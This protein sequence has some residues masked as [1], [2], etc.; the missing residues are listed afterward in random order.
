MQRF[1]LATA[2]IVAALIT[3]P[4][5]GATA[6]PALGG[7]VAAS[8]H[9]SPAAAHPA[10]RIRSSSTR[11]HPA[12]GV[13]ASAAVS[14]TIPACWGETGG[15]VEQVAGTTSPLGVGGTTSED[16]DTFA[17]AFN[18]IRIANCLPPIELKNFHY[19]SCMEA[20]LFWMAEDP[21]EDPA[22]AWGHM[23]SVRSDG[24][25]STGCDGNLAGGSGN[26]GAT[27]AQKWWDSLPH[28]ASLYRPGSAIGGVCIMF[29]M[30]HGGVPNEQYDFTR[31][32]ARW[33]DC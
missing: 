20:R 32:A 23:G 7:K 19:D 21:S 18:S 4:A 11:D 13:I 27:V 10:G 29:A 8:A 3:L 2:F 31:A 16:L 6:Q 12:A 14:V 28:R 17:R 26:T 5:I 9:P 15:I 30:T 1:I 33:V 25:P 22:S 24:L